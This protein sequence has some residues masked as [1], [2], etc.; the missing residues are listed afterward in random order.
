M[1]PLNG[2]PI[3]ARKADPLIEDLAVVA[4][5]VLNDVETVSL[6]PCPII[7]RQKHKS[8]A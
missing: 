5:S 6:K 4:Q 2:L 8:P 7:E 1:T 3:G